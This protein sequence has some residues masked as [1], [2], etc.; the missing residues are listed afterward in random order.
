MNNN[1]KLILFC[2]LS[3]V[4]CTEQ[5]CEI[6]SICIRD[7][8]GNYILKWE[9]NPPMEGT[10]RFYVS[11]TPNSFNMSQPAGYADIKVWRAAM[12]C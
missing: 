11:D 9:T 4:G 10:M 2:L 5:T 6:R 12:S 7:N 8:I 3:L 1:L